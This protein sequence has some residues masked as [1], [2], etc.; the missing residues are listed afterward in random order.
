MEINRDVGVLKLDWLRQFLPY[1][2][3]NVDAGH[4]RVETRRAL[5]G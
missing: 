1:E 3:K 5:K 4:G 2:F